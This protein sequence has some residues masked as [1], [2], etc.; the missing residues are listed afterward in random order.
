MVSGHQRAV[1]IFSDRPRTASALQALQDA[2]FSMRDVSVIARDANHQSAIAGV[3]VDN[4]VGNHSQEGGV[5]G[6]VTGGA[7]GG[8]AGLLVGLGV[9][10]I[11]GIGPAVLAGEVAAILTTLVGG[12]AGAVAGGLAGAL[13]GLGI[14]EHRAKRYSDRVAQGHYLVML[15]GSDSEL[16]KA[17]RIL[18]DLG[19]EDWGVYRQPHSNRHESSVL[20]QP[21]TQPHAGE[22]TNYSVAHA[23]QPGSAHYSSTPARGHISN[24]IS[25]NEFER[26]NERI[27]RGEFRP[28]LAAESFNPYDQLDHPD[29]AVDSLVESSLEAEPHELSIDSENPYTH[30]DYLQNPHDVSQ[31]RSHLHT[32]THVGR[33]ETSRSNV[34]SSEYVSSANGGLALHPQRQVDMPDV[35]AKDEPTRSEYNWVPPAHEEHYSQVHMPQFTTDVTPAILADEEPYSQAQMPK[36][37]TDVTPRFAPV[38]PNP[39]TIDNAVDETRP[40]I[41][42]PDFTAKAVASEL[43][44]APSDLNLNDE[45]RAIGRFSQRMQMESALRALQQT[46]FPMHRLSIAVREPD[47]VASEPQSNALAADQN[48]NSDSTNESAHPLQGASS[49]LSGLNRVPIPTIGNLLM[50]GSDSYRLMNAV[51]EQR[52][53]TVAEAL[54]QL[55]LA[56]ESVPLYERHLLEGA[57][58]V[59]LQGDNQDVLQAASVLGQHGMRDWGVYDLHPSVR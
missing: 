38:E 55:G 19:I 3:A 30:V 53:H 5:V 8:I 2:G 41:Q 51:Y 4:H 11:P 14:P 56:T 52:V 1:G 59:T 58:L 22:H 37:T 15:K 32:H 12:A 27:D 47:H 21:L 25:Q 26:F 9:L 6:A 24:A 29:N 33:D 48:C 43:D 42:M 46:G 13:I 28:H 50:I 34:G 57:Y 20:T 23:A 17:E 36:F 35:A 16:G 49:V 18:G 7:L 10:T 45:R 39:S 31:K 40:P 44:I 54:Q